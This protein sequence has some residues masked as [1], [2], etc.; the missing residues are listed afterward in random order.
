MLYE[1]LRGDQFAHVLAIGPGAKPQHQT[2]LVFRP[3]HDRLLVFL[4]FNGIDI[5]ESP[6]SPF[7]VLAHMRM[8]LEELTQISMV[9]QEI[10][11]VCQPGIVSEFGS[12][13]RV[14]IEQMIKRI[15]LI[16]ADVFTRCREALFSLHKPGGVFA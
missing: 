7:Q 4:R 12:G 2:V 8:V 16:P 1:S 9:T 10:T 14:K 15:Q 6:R 11:I 3:I 13:L 5:H